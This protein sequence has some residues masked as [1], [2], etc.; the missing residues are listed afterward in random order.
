M[1]RR[2]FCVDPTL[3]M[4]SRA[5]LITVNVVWLRLSMYLGYI[6]MC[7]INRLDVIKTDFFFH[8]RCEKVPKDT[9]GEEDRVRESV[10]TSLTLGSSRM[11]E[12]T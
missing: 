11:S 5:S 1:V 10:F 4:G 7:E 3:I 12:K 8:A 6:N 9:R 2:Y